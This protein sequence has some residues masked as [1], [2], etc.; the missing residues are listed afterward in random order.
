MEEEKD[1]NRGNL[2]EIGVFKLM[3]GNTTK[4]LE[5]WQGTRTFKNAKVILKQIP[6][7]EF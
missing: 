7:Q 1:A 4:R 2:I 5:I 3:S 6:T